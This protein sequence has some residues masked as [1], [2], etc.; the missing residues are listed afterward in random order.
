MSE[1]KGRI[2]FLPKAHLSPPAALFVQ[3]FASSEALDAVCVL[4]GL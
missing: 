1:Q 2:Y 3:L 4:M